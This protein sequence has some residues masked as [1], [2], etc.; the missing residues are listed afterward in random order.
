[1]TVVKQTDITSNIGKYFDMAHDG[2]PVIVQRKN[3]RNVVIISEN[4]YKE[5]EKHKRNA[6][7]LAMIERS[8]GQARDGGFIKTTMEQLESF[9]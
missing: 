6:E 3:G 7:Y 9:E 8:M 1:M 2:E 5:F 4:Y